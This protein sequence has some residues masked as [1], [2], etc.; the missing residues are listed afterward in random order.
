MNLAPSRALYILSALSLVAAILLEI[1]R[2]IINSCE[3]V[4]SEEVQP[5]NSYVRVLDRWHA[6][7]VVLF[8]RNDD[9]GLVVRLGCSLQRNHN[10]YVKQGCFP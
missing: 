9:V 3:R 10:L 8:P 7:V 5:C 2:G 6:L 1:S 4:F